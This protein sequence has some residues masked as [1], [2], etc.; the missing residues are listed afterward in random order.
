MV[1]SLFSYRRG[2]SILHRTPAL[3]KL[4]ILFILCIVTFLE[5]VLWW[6]TALCGLAAAVLFCL[7]GFWWH[8]LQ[9]MKFVL[10][11]GALLT[12]FRMF[13]LDFTSTPCIR[14]VYDEMIAGIYWT[15][16]FFITTWTAQTI[17]ETTSSLEIQEAFEKTVGGKAALVLGLAITFIP[18]VFQ[19]WTKVH[20][21]SQA[22]SP[23][24]KPS[25][26]QTVR[27]LTV[28]L[29]AFFS[30]LIQ[31]AMTVQKAVSNRS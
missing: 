1:V 7:G 30:C 28:E 16:H 15:I 25:L 23:K 18:L 10:I 6:K 8:A 24:G 17:F 4:A 21:A 3:V 26:R 11:L 31:Q 12:L 14:F 20:L 22:R 19:T 5:P 29:E 27:N 9:Q 2:N 13:Q